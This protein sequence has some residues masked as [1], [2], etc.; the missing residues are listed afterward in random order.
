MSGGRHIIIGA[1]HNGL[2]AACLMARAGLKPLVLERRAQCGG[3]AVTEEIHP[4]FRCPTLLHTATSS[5]KPLAQELDLARHGLEVIQP[6]VRVFA[7]SP[8]G[9]GLTIYEDP[10]RTAR[11]MARVSARDAAR[12]PE[13]VE[14]FARIGGFLR[15]IMFMAPPSID[16]PSMAELMRLLG[17][18]RRFR[19]LGKKDGYRL[20]RWG[21]MAVADLV[22]EWFESDL[23][24]ATVAAR[25][26]ANTFAGPWSA[27]TS[28]GLLLQAAHDGHAVA[29]SLTFRGGIGALGTALAAA[30][31]GSGAEI[32]TSA[33]VARIT[34]KDG[35]VAS[36]A[37]ES[38]EEIPARAIIASTDPRTTLLR[39]VDPLDL[40]P[41]FAHKVRS[42]RCQ[43][44]AA[45]LNYAL[46]GSPRFAGAA[47]GDGAALMAG[48]IHIGP[49]IDYL[50]R[51]F[52]AAKYGAYAPHPVLDITIPS[53]ADPSLAPS[54][55]QVMSVHAQF[56]P[57]ALKAGDWG[58]YREALADAVERTIEEHAP[59]F[60]AL[61]VK[62]QVLTPRDIE[63]AYGLSGGHL[64]HGEQA[65]DQLFTMRPL[66][67]WARYRAP[68][69]GLYLCGAGTHP[70]G[71]ITGTPGLN[72][73]REILRDL[74]R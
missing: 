62:R 42:Y 48:R 56:A 52:D 37:L 47:A 68:I 46:S 28:L 2:V 20:L 18:G 30:A 38:G 3:V 32:R 12:Y 54:G 60:R 16:A 35:A 11:E 55:A 26:I 59:G 63:S 66:L 25:G 45:K 31:Q 13:F 5:L 14:A 41:D 15:P 74:K 73:A 21:P 50:E 69:K 19:A 67:G 72:A 70:G 6:E 61:V 71:G 8:G 57:Y 4:G 65:L 22:A 40:D 33:A 17:V 24:R 10:A 49:E 53:L 64:F 9:A 7:P 44:V 36:V 51:A 29:P 34:C 39:L 43:G 27:G 1:G 58:A 23:L